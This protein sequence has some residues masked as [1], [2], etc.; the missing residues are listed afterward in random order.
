[1]ILISLYK[2]IQTLIRL[3]VVE[4]LMTD[5]CETGNL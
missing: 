5:I 2:T 1:M 3:E 4:V